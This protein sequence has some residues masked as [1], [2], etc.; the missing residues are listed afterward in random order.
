MT[1]QEGRAEDLARPGISEE[2]FK[3]AV[4]VFEIL[5]MWDL[6]QKENGD[7]LPPNSEDTEPLSNPPSS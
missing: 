5:K 3:N 1:K 4:R 6:R 7:K 2:E